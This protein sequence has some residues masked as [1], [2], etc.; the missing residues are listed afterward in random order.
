MLPWFKDNQ[1]PLYLAPMAGV[2]DYVFREICKNLGADT[3][4]TEFVSAEG[5]L[6]QDERTRRYTEFPDG[7]R[8]VGVQLFGSHPENLAKAAQKVVNWK[9]P[10]FIDINFGCPVNKVVS[11]NGGSSMLRDCPALA[12]VTEALVKAV[13]VPVTAK[14]RI[15]W[16]Q[17]SINAVHICQ[18]LESTGVQ[19]IAIHGRTRAQG[20]TGL[21]DW[22]VIGECA[23]SVRIPV[24][25]NGD[26]AS[27]ADV[28]KRRRETRVSGVMIGRA[29]MQYPWVFR[30]AKHYLKTGKQPTPASANERWELMRQHAAMAIARGHKGNERQTLTSMRSRLMAYSKGLPG[31]KSLRTRF[32]HLSSITELEDIAAEHLASLNDLSPRHR[33]LNGPQLAGKGI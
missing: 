26:I 27:G 16:D 23:E 33:E 30:D 20:Y 4:V 15:G 14:I 8:P 28:E 11:R 6:Q 3:L 13:D 24:I 32:A 18:L 12:A 9:R 21:A 17:N 31:G 1:F 5:I 19:A 2:T 29:A 10:E 22:E 25:G 7:Q